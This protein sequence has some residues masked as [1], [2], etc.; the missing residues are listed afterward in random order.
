MWQACATGMQHKLSE[1]HRERT[2][3]L[4]GPRASAYLAVLR[5]PLLLM[6][7]CRHQT[8]QAEGH[9]GILQDTIHA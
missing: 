3:V 1:R 2:M 7:N 9:I 6:M 5:R 4:S 8:R